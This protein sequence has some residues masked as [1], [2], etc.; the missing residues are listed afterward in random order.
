MCRRWMEKT[1]RWVW[2]GGLLGGAL[3]AACCGLLPSTVTA[4]ATPT[5]LTVCAGVDDVAD[6]WVNSAYIGNFAFTQ[7]PTPLPCVT[8]V[9]PAFLTTNGTNLMAVRLRNTNPNQMWATW[10]LSVDF[11]DGSAAYWDSSSSGVLSYFALHDCS[12][13]PPPGGPASWVDPAFTPAPDWGSAVTVTAGVYGNL[14]DDPQ[15]GWPLAPLATNLDGASTDTCDAMFF[16]QPFAIVPLTATPTLSPTPSF[17]PTPTPTLSWTPT[18]TRTP[19]ATLTRTWTPTPT[20]SPTPTDTRTATRTPTPTSTRTWTGTPTWTR[21]FTPTPTVT[22]TFTITWT[23]TVTNTPTVTRTPT[24]TDTPTITLT[25]TITN[26]PTVTPTF[27][28]GNG[29]FVSRNVFCPGFDA[30]PLLLRVSTGAG[31]LYSLK[32]Y[33]SAGEKVRTLRETRTYEGVHEFVFWDG[34]TDRG[35]KAAS[36]IYLFKL[37]TTYGTDAA[38][39]LLVR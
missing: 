4:Q 37:L 24:V 5:A 9:G 28:A 6:V 25:P 3:L 34:L 2:T 26:T 1:T 19:T 11:S 38:R 10:N 31:G 33:N 16:R 21:T 32:V 36:G 15:T 22:N 23:P 13:D 12:L 14:A 20:Q 27:P 18:A 30:G 7:G 17:T 29:F 39:V 8:V 35:E